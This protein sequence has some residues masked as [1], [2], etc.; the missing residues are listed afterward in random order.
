MCT[1]SQL[2][3][4]LNFIKEKIYC[5]IVDKSNNDNILLINGEWKTIDGLPLDKI[6]ELSS[7]TA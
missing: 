5:C 1:D 6:T 3:Q 2:N 4:C 7:L